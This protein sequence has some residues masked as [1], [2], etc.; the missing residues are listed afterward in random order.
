MIKAVRC[1]LPTF[2]NVYFKKGFNIILGER[3]DVSSEK[4][5][6]NG[7]GKSLLID[8]INFCLGASRRN[9]KVMHEVLK[10]RTF[11]VDMDI[12]GIDVTVSRNT[13]DPNFVYLTNIDVDFLSGIKF[14][15]EGNSFKIKN[16]DWTLLLGSKMFGLDLHR[17]K[18]T[19]SFRSLISYFIRQNFL[20]PFKTSTRQSEWDIQVSNAFLL[21]LEWKHAREFHFVKEREKTLKELK[22]ASDQGIMDNVFGSLSDLR[23]TQV[24]L[25]RKAEKIA[26]D[27]ENFR[28]HPRYKEIEIEAD[29]LTKEIHSLTNKNIRDRKRLSQYE[30]SLQEEVDEFSS[31]HILDVYNEAKILFPN[32]VVKRLEDVEQFHKNLVAN[33]RSF[34]KQEINRLKMEIEKR[35]KLIAQKSSERA[36]LL[37]ILDAYGAL[38]EYTRL[39]QNYTEI[40]TKLNDIEKRIEN[41]NK[42]QE[43]KSQ[44]KIEKMI[45]QQ[46]ARHDFNDRF[47]IWKKNIV[48]FSQNTEELYNVPGKLIVDIKEK[49]FDFKVTI[50][51]SG[52]SGVDNMKIF[53]YDLTLAEI[54]SGKKNSPQFLIHDSNLF[55]PVDERQ[56]ALA[57]TLAKKR[58]E[59]FGFQYICALN[60]DQI[61]WDYLP[62]DFN[63]DKFTSVILDDTEKGGLL[64]FRY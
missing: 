63:V 36:R 30:E 52:S 22:K 46:K 37:S 8:I 17:E 16:D 15:R 26:N 57:L 60:S 32:R 47:Q 7:V 49:G 35:D 12:G 11:I 41:L 51:R 54:W 14:E 21:D 34:L 24:N 56:R 19:P 10:G 4:D 25:K 43:G 3:A 59:E 5:S 40:L 23:A 6:R 48:R 45:L 18:Y 29:T 42:L 13:N 53:C 39:Q 38:E 20:S 1:D 31:Q 55:D 27:L 62:D 58:S 44:I 64:G 33:R 9:R 61:P 50:E 28:V 2:K